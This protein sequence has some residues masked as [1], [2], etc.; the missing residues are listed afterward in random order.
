MLKNALCLPLR[1]TSCP[2]LLLLGFLQRRAMLVPVS[3]CPQDLSLTKEG[4]SYHPPLLNVDK[5]KTGWPLQSVCVHWL[6]IISPSLSR[7]VFAC[8]PEI[9]KTINHQLAGAQEPYPSRGG[10]ASSELSRSLR[11]GCDLTDIL[12]KGFKQPSFLPPKHNLC[13]I[14]VK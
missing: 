11:R 2:M 6:W 10:E 5:Q 4:P 12:S 8:C 1:H 9:Q 7:P 13:F 3:S 14:N